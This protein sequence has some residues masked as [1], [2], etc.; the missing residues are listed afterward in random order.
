MICGIQTTVLLFVS[1]NLVTTEYTSTRYQHVD[2]MS[3][4]P[5]AIGAMRMNFSGVI[6]FLSQQ[7]ALSTKACMRWSPRPME[8]WFQ[9][10]VAAM[11]LKN[12]RKH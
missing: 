7:V 8:F 10:C 6:I 11:E 5:P 2:S 1:L 4:F 12:N 3:G 9:P